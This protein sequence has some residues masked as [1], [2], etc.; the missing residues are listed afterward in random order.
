MSY[1]SKTGKYISPVG[2]ASFPVLITPKPVGKSPKA[3]AV[4]KYQLTIVFGPEAQETQDY[5]DLKAAV[6]KAAED[7]WGPK[8]SPSRPRK[9]KTP[10][11]TTE[12]LRNKVPE[13]YTDED[14][15]LRLH[16]TV[17]PE[18]VEKIGG[19]V[20]TVKDADISKVLYAG[21]DIR[22]AMDIYAWKN[23]EGG[24][25]VSFGLG[26]V[27]KVADND[28]W[29]ASQSDAADDFGFDKEADGSAGDDF[30]G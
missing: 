3:D 26:N 8:G 28:P 13:G 18:V 4:E 9:I 19:K 16:S 1:N 21:C 2:R 20:R 22:V 15:F 14:T 11:L 30:L 12:D 17:K 23:D 6:V 29:G 24:C 5:K 10:F 7:K 25:G 27:M